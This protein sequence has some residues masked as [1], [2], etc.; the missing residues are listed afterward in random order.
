MGQL[1]PFLDGLYLN[2]VHGELVAEIIH[3]RSLSL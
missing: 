1:Q 3:K 2:E